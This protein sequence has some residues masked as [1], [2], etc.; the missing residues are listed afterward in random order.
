MATSSGSTARPRTNQVPPPT[1]QLPD[2]RG[3]LEA[4][5]QDRIASQ[6]PVSAPFGVQLQRESRTTPRTNFTIGLPGQ[7]TS[8]ATTDPLMNP[9]R[10]VQQQRLDDWRSSLMGDIGRAEGALG[11]AK[12]NERIANLLRLASVEES[13]GQMGQVGQ[14]FQDFQEERPQPG[15]Q[16]LTRQV[17]AAPK[18]DKATQQAQQQRQAVLQAGNA[19]IEAA[20]QGGQDLL[21]EAK[22]LAGSLYADVLSMKAEELKSW[23]NDAAKAIS[24]QRGAIQTAQQQTERQIID[25]YAQMGHDRRSP[26]VQN[27]LMRSRQSM[28]QNIGDI[29]SQIQMQ[30]NSAHAQI[31]KE[32]HDRIAAVSLPAA[33][34]T[35]AAASEGLGLEQRAR[36]LAMGARLSADQLASQTAI[37]A[38]QIRAQRETALSQ[39][40]AAV[41]EAGVKLDSLNIYNQAQLAMA[42]ESM[43]LSGLTKIADHL[44]NYTTGYV[45]LSPAFAEIAERYAEFELSNRLIEVAGADLA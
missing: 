43:R 13:S 30:Y 32:A 22:D 28:Q 25:Q 1:L 42:A 20:I 31:L 9:D 15:I 40:G 38:E 17:P 18:L 37:Q 33:Q 19:A 41:W 27:A 39:V 29:S 21:S 6:R 3:D 34:M 5:V 7:P 24:V 10:D 35:L 45:A 4:S 11:Q 2:F 26:T 44:E 12:E 14:M 8:S 23:T 16:D 36:E